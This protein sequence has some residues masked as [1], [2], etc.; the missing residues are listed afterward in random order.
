M[1]L[2][3]AGEL[4]IKRLVGYKISEAFLNAGR[5]PQVFCLVIILFI[6]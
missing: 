3:T 5:S 1:V 4:S 6:R 2:G